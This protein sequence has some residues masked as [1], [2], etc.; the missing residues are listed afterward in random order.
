MTIP[1]IRTFS[2]VCASVTPQV[3]NQHVISNVPVENLLRRKKKKSAAV[4]QVRRHPQL[5][6]LNTF[7]AAKLSPQ[8]VA[9]KTSHSSSREKKKVSKEKKLK[10]SEEPPRN[11]LDA[12]APTT[13]HGKVKEFPKRKKASRFKR[14]ILQEREMRY[15]VIK[16]SKLFLEN[17]KKGPKDEII[18]GI[19]ETVNEDLVESLEIPLNELSIEDDPLD[20]K[21]L[22]E[23]SIHSNRYRSYCQQ[24]VDDTIDKLA[25]SLLLDLIR[26]QDKMHQKDP[27]KAQSRRRFCCGFREAFKY[28]TLKK[29]KCFIVA[30]D[31]QMIVKDGVLDQTLDKLTAEARE[32]GTPVVFALTRTQLAYV[33]RR[34]KAK[35]SVIAILNPDGSNETFKQLIEESDRARDSYFQIRKEL[36]NRLVPLEQDAKVVKN[37]IRQEAIQKLSCQSY[38]WRSPKPNS[39]SLPS[40]HVPK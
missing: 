2:E 5:L 22:V 9:A 27:Q 21:K 31:V 26:F 4:R 37:Q 10:K 23:N 24:V 11:P 35:I 16:A 40:S 17:K 33:C 38:F 39:P 32:S 34:P 1:R 15:K 12:T 28:L 8:K 18:C 6:T 14:V 20:L 3:N 30:P 29:V 7:L 36:M 25:T 19:T 13:R